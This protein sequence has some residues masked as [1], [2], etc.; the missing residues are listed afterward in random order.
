MGP[1]GQC[2]LGVPCGLHPTRRLGCAWSGSRTSSSIRL[3]RGGAA[4]GGPLDSGRACARQVCRRSFARRRARG[5]R[6][7]PQVSGSPAAFG[8]KFSGP[9]SAAGRQHKSHPLRSLRSC[10]TL[11]LVDSTGIQDALCFDT[12]APLIP[13]SR[14]SS[15]VS[16]I[17][18]LSFACPPAVKGNLNYFSKSNK[19][20][21]QDRKRRRRCCS[22][23][24]WRP[25]KQ[26]EGKGWGEGGKGEVFSR[27]RCVN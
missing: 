19:V 2:P 16:S 7:R 9:A 4:T 3:G 11:S 27:V 17:V 21:V 22:S 6:R 13:L 10:C 25:Q 15:R 12:S 23:H 5:S 26:K 14:S 24:Q 20:V 8:L 18:A 1:W